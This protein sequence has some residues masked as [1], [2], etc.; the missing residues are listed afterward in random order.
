MINPTTATVT[1]SHII[2]ATTRKSN[3]PTTGGARIT[4]TIGK[5]GCH[6]YGR[7]TYPYDHALT[8]DAN[9]AEALRQYSNELGLYGQWWSASAGDS[10]KTRHAVC[11]R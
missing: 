4:V 11:V 3:S 5:R 7:K 8:L 1:L 2:A 9:H 10:G 6:G